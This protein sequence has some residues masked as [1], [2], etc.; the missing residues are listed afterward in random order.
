MKA[1]KTRLHVLL[2]LFSCFLLNAPSLPQMQMEKRRA[3]TEWAST[4]HFQFNQKR[5]ALEIPWE[6]GFSR[7]CSLDNSRWSQGGHLVKDLPGPSDFLSF[8]ISIRV[9]CL[10]DTQE[11]KEGL[12]TRSSTPSS[13]SSPSENKTTLPKT[14]TGEGPSPGKEGCNNYM[15]KWL[16][17]FC[18]YFFCIAVLLLRTPTQQ[19]GRNLPCCVHLFSFFPLTEF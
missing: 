10:V 3:G 14:S 1:L 16:T 15:S 17:I 18:R 19:Q 12:L 7:I 6:R 2:T 4:Q 8:S 9:R 11:A 5:K 13:S